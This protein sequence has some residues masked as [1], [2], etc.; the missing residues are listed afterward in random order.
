MREPELPDKLADRDGSSPLA[1]F[2]ADADN[3]HKRQG[4]PSVRCNALY[5]TKDN[6]NALLNPSQAIELAQHLLQKAQLIIDNQ[7]DDAAV[8][9]WNQGADNERFYCGLNTARKGPRRKKKKA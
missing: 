6:V 1:E 5:K 3:E 7:L 8:H 2:L 4:N 9:L